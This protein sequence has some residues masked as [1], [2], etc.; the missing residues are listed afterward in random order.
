MIAS[1]NFGRY[2][3]NILPGFKKEVK[4]FEIEKA[5]GM[6]FLFCWFPIRILKNMRD[7]GGGHFGEPLDD[8]QWYC[9]KSAIGTS[10]A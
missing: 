9:P 2:V 6:C 5:D 7:F 4:S 10:K 8:I 3:W 1:Q